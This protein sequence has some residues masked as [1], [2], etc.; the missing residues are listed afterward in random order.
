MTLE[1]ALEAY[2]DRFD[3]NFPIFYLRGMP[4]SELIRLIQDCLNQGKP[5]EVPLLHDE[6]G[7]PIVY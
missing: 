4:E 6:N 5:Y 7:L 3:E 2:A 1:Q